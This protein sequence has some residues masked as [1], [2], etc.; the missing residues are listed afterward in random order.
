M[1]GPLAGQKILDSNPLYRPLCHHD[2]GRSRC[3]GA[4]GGGPEPAR[5]CAPGP[6]YDGEVS[7][8]QMAINR[9]KRSIALNLKT[10][11]GVALA[12]RLVKTYDIVLEQFRPGVMKRLGTLIKPDRVTKEFAELPQ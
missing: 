4:Q 6:P 11:E 8:V 1:P 12:K 5:Q 7:A 2:V 9:N 10:P 3:R